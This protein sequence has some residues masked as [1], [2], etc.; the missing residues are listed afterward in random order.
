MSNISS[1]DMTHTVTNPRVSH[2]VELSRDG[3]GW[4]ID[5]LLIENVLF[6]GDPMVL[7]P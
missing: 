5:Y 1:L 6:S 7:L 3:D 4:V 2:R